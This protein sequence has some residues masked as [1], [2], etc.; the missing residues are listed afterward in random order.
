[1]DFDLPQGID[2][3]VHSTASDGTYTPAEI[4]ATAQATG[5]QAISITDHDTVAGTKEALEKASLFSV[6]VLSGIEMS[7]ALPDSKTHIKGSFHVLGYGIDVKNEK[8]LST[9]QAFQAIRK[10]RTRQIIQKLQQLGCAIDIADFNGITTTIGRPHIAQ[11]MIEK[12]CVDSFNDAFDRYLGKDKPAYVDKYRLP[13]RETATLL[14]SAGGIPVLAHPGLLSIQTAQ[15]YATLFEKLHDLGLVGIEALYPLHT[16]AQ[17]RLFLELA[18]T[19]GL[20][21]T[22]GSDFHGNIK[23]EIVLGEGDRS[24][25]VPYSLYKTLTQRLQEM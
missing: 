12:G 3:H 1:M 16:L 15:E 5:L 9:L 7:A 14:R 25:F 10:N 24:F 6:K 23:P 18:K 20:L 22:G 2:L 13:F 11:K 8:L 4:L 17:T 19:Y 21:I